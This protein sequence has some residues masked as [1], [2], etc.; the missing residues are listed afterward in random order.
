MAELTREQQDRGLA[1]VAR[2]L[3]EEQGGAREMAAAAGLSPG[4]LKD[5]FCKNWETVKSVLQFLSGY[6]PKA[7]RPIVT[8]IITAG[9]A[10]HGAICHP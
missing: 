2:A 1:A 5:V 4:D 9:D 3:N 6:L 8:I 7:L 10:L